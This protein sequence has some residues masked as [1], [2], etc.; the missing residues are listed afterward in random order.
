[1]LDNSV[2]KKITKEC[3]QKLLFYVNKQNIIVSIGTVWK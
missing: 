3:F 2:R 1:M